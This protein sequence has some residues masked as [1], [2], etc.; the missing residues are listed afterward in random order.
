M[1]VADKCSSALYELIDVNN[2]FSSFYILGQYFGQNWGKTF[3]SFHAS[4]FTLFTD[5]CVYYN[6]GY[7]CWLQLFFRLIAIIDLFISLPVF[8]KRKQ[9]LIF[10]ASKFGQENLHTSDSAYSSTSYI[11]L[12][13]TNSLIIIKKLCV[14]LWTC[15][16]SK[17]SLP[18][19]RFIR[20]SFYKI[21]LH[22]S[23]NFH[24]EISVVIFINM[25]Y[26]VER[27][28]ELVGLGRKL[29]LP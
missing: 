13:F 18:W 9:Y 8:V 20:I 25:E 10:V 3:F 1:H 14:Q 15:L 6:C 23:D 22:I 11:F 19:N 27:K 4:V 7:V 29:L 21:C 17:L 26:E 2:L 16:W 5:F 24:N 12:L 28:I